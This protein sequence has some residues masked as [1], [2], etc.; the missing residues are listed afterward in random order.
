MTE[1]PARPRGSSGTD[2][3][4]QFTPSTSDIRRR[5]DHRYRRVRRRWRDGSAPHPWSPLS[6][7]PVVIS[8]RG[9]TRPVRRRRPVALA[10]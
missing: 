3:T 2:R 6:P 5:G 1:G 10:V 8:H 4:G 7:V 9:G